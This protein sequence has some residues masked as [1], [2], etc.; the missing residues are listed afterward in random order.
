MDFLGWLKRSSPW[1]QW[2]I[3]LVPIRI[4][5]IAIVPIL[6]EE[7]YH[8]NFGRHLD[9]SYYDHPPV[10]AW[11][12]AAGRLVFGD[13]VLGVRALP[14]L[15]SMGTSA[16]IARLAKRFYSDAAAVWAVILF[17]IAP[18]AFLVSEAGFPDSPLLFFWTLAMALTWRAI[19]G[20]NGLWWL[21][22][23]AAL[24]AAML[25]KYTAVMLVPGVLLHLILSAGDRRWLRTP[26]PYLAG[27]LALAVFSPV[28]YWNWKHEWV[29]F[30]FQTEGRM[31][32]ARG[33][34]G[35]PI[36]F[37][38][39]QALAFF[40][41]TLPLLVATAARLFRTDR[42][43][44]RFLGTCAIPVFVLF[45]IVS[46]SRPA[47]LVWPLPGYLGLLVVMSGVAAEGAGAIARFYRRTRTGLLWAS[48]LALLG[49][50]IHLAFFLPGLAP[51]QGPYG[52]KEVAERARSLR[53]SLPPSAFYLALGR[54]YTCTSQLAYQLNL[55]YEVHG[56]NLIGERAL[57]YQFWSDPA[58]LKGRDAVIVIEGQRR[59]TQLEPALKQYFDRIETAGK[60]EV[61]VG[62]TPLRPEAPLTFHLYRA[63][64]YGPRETEAESK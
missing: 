38:L 40:P 47:H 22:A 31:E 6:P 11:S 7:A 60:V 19:E 16:L 26:W 55:P 35:K 52:W 13:T 62:R 25:S 27:F 43:E 9:W 24:G 46:F 61:P 57:Q 8:W 30:L 5:L 18:V 14:L 48:G 17:T 23:G 29:S 63:Y 2:L 59:T 53:S 45:W 54:K 20:R 1:V 44:E 15:F 10:I 64:G 32:E 41:L 36:R 51:L 37:L 3:A 56:A 42:P 12:I 4:A 39:N 50:A 34:S 58:S 33:T 28:I 21:P 49:G